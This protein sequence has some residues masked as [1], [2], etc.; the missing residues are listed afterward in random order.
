MNNQLAFISRIRTALGHSPGL[1]RRPP[2]GL[3]PDHPAAHSRAG[4]EAI[5]KRSTEERMG[6]L[7]RLREVARPLQIRVT[8]VSDAAKASAVIVDLV[9]RAELEFDTRKRAA[10][11]RHPLVDQLNLKTALEADNVH[12]TVTDP[13][14]EI[15][16]GESV[17][18]YQRVI[19]DGVA[20]SAVGITSADYCVA[21]TA[22]LVI[23][24]A[25]GCDRSVSLLPTVHV[26]VITLDQLIKDL[27]ELYAVLRW[28]TDGSPEE[29]PHCL[30]MITGPSK[31]GDIEAVMV[32]GVHGPRELH[33]IVITGNG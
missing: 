23:K 22:T 12:L 33:L 32:P 4:L 27:G 17:S 26:A 5:A 19:R 18:A 13:P 28:E 7:E 2:R 10:A 20:R 15:H 14:D 21:D 9:D 1:R 25:P 11:W 30:T 29:L 8:A 16:D 3:F 31:T 24:A 6:L